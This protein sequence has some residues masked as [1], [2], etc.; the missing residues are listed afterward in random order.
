MYKSK[1][2]PNCGGPEVYDVI[3]LGGGPAGL[4]AGIYASRERLKTLLLEGPMPGGLMATTELVEN[5]PGFPDGASGME[6]AEAMKKQAQKFGAEIIQE[7]AKSV[8]PVGDLIEVKTD[9]ETYS[10]HAVRVA[11]GT[12]H[13]KL[14]IPGEEEFH[15]KGVAYCATCDGPLF[16]D[17]D[18]AV[19]GAGN[20]GLQEGEFLL[21]F[22]NSVTF[23]EFLPHMTA[24]KILQERVGENEK[25]KFL[26]NHELTAVNGDKMVGSVTVKGRETGEEKTI[27]VAGV[28]IY[29]GLLPNTGIL[30]GV[31][32][33]DDKGYVVT[34]ERMETSVPGIYA[35]GD[36]RPTPVRQAT[37][38]VGDGTTAAIIA[39]MYV[40]EKKR[41]SGE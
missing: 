8:K 28:F 1:S 41:G 18:V 30:K 14:G 10:T 4:S 25:A 29:A 9:E 11:T 6:L 15:N 20:S 5:Y 37:T 35:A 24:A 38:A 13:K 40:E 36:V 39:G 16:A 31:V 2:T 22:V 19:I 23:I 27:E 33:L 32:E 17:R 21:K 3:I 7:E 12:I 34:N 26:L